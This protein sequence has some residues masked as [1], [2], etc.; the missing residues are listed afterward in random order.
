[1]KIIVS[2]LRL[3]LPDTGGPVTG[4]PLYDSPGTGGNTA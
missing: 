3:K 1:M 2:L 4:P